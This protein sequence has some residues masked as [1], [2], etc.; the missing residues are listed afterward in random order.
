MEKRC[1]ECFRFFPSMTS[2]H[3]DCMTFAAGALSISMEKRL[4]TSL[5]LHPWPIAQCSYM[6]R[7]VTVTDTQAE[8]AFL[9]GYSS[10]SPPV[11]G[12]LYMPQ[13]RRWSCFVFQ[14]LEH[15]SSINCN[16]VHAPLQEVCLV[17]GPDQLVSLVLRTST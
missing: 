3:I 15:I 12:T 11:T 6:L 16:F 8:A 17:T 13:F 5:S 2:T 4:N 10:T 9:F 14:L 1:T 7:L